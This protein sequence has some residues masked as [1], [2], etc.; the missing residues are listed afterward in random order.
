MSAERFRIGSLPYLNVRPL[1]AGLPEA[2]EVHSPRDLAERLRAGVI[3]AG[4]VPVAACFEEGRYD[5]LDGVAIGCDGPVFSV[6]VAHRRPIEETQ[7]IVVDR[8]SRTSALLLEVLLREYWRIEPRRRVAGL[9]AGPGDAPAALLIGDKAIRVNLDPGPYTI[10]D[11]G[12][13]W[14][15]H[16][17]LPFVFAVWAL[18]PGLHAGALPSILARA[19]AA[20]LANPAGLLRPGDEFPGEFVLRYLTENVCFELGPAQKAAI[21]RFRHALIEHRLLPVCHPLRYITA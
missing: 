13:V 5:V 1:V 16:T 9:E 17:G 7:E 20:G 18:R 10:T 14:K 11:L 12:A 4:I 2:L 15:A 8:S 3:D 19:K 21:E 6:I